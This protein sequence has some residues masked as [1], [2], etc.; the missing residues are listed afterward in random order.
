MSFDLSSLGWDD[1]LAT[2]YVRYH[3]PSRCP[4]R[5]SR[6]DHGVCTALAAGGAV[7]ASLAGTMLTAA[8][9]DPVLLPCI[10]DWV[11]VH[12]WRD[13]RIT[14]GGG[15]PWATGIVRAGGGPGGHGQVFA[16]KDDA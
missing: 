5:V 4:A 11:V 16:P 2:A 13:R 10:V 6:V 1:D 3:R 8:A 9:R 15:L 14:V 12:T 7:R